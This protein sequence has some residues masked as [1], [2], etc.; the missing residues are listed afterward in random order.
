M[1]VPLCAW[2][3]CTHLSLS[4]QVGLLPVV[5]HGAGPQLNKRMEDAGVTPEFVGGIRVTDARTLA[6]ARDVFY[7][8]NMKLAEALERAGTRARPIVGMR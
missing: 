3:T 4:G 8:E 2:L 7:E 5:I 6:V 1:R